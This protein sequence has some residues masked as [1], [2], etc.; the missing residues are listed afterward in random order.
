M[1][2]HTPE[3]ASEWRAQADEK[4][5]PFGFIVLSPMRV[6]GKLLHPGQKIAALEKTEEPALQGPAIYHRDIFD[7]DR[8]NILLCNLNDVPPGPCIGSV[9]EIGYCARME[10]KPAIIVVARK[11]TAFRG[12]PMITTPA[13][14]IFEEL[15]PAYEFIIN[16]FAVFN[17]PAPMWLVSGAGQQHITL[18]PGIPRR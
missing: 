10:P 3:Q 13:H 16:N 1:T 2:G 7:L 4:L 11:G 6:E 8:T 12:H 17:G 5:T 14:A 18:E 9:F 15:E